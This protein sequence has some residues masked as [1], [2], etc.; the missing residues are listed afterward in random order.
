MVLNFD[1]L[2]PHVMTPLDY[3]NS[4]HRQNIYTN[5]QNSNSKTIMKAFKLKHPFPLMINTLM[6]KWKTTFI[7]TSHAVVSQTHNSENFCEF[8]PLY[9]RKNYEFLKTFD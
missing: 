6:T 4:D 1:K 7:V 5:P 8:E 3:D 2:K 9:D